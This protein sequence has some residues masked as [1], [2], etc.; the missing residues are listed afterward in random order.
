MRHEFPQCSFQ[1]TCNRAFLIQI[2]FIFWKC[3]TSHQRCFE[4]RC[5]HGAVGWLLLEVCIQTKL[6]L[7]GWRQPRWMDIWPFSLTLCSPA[8]FR[9][10]VWGKTCL[11]CW[12]AVRGVQSRGKEGAV[13]QDGA[14]LA[15]LCPGLGWPQ[16]ALAPRSLPE[17]E[18]ESE[19]GRG[20]EVA[21]E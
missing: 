8:L 10:I 14:V 21:C 12:G 17:R 16:G 18:R 11:T 19:T 1:I 3:V 5:L 20:T 2:L 15:E 6:E 13:G 4:S 9:G 7:A